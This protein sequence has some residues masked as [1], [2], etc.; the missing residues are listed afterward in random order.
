MTGVHELLDAARNGGMWEDEVTLRNEG[1]IIKTDPSKQL[2]F[3]WAY[4]MQ[5]KEGGQVIDKSGDFID[6][7]DELEKAAYGFVL[8]S[9]QSDADHTNVSGGTMVESMIFTPEKIAK[10]GLPEGSVPLGWWVGFKIEDK[11]TWG[12]VERGE[13][14]KFSIHGKGV[15]QKVASDS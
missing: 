6:D 3:G 14:T 15:R 1:E 9:R 4:V 13:L 2:V 10:M 8:E 11:D 12:R 5:T 7:I